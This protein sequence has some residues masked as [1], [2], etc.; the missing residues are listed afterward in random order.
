M[1]LHERLRAWRL[2]EGLTQRQAAKLA[3]ITQCR[4]SE[5]ESG[6]SVPTL[7]QAF[8]IQRA[9][10]GKIRADAWPKPKRRRAA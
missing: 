2:A 5:I 3:E 1:P 6:M 9:T 7:H 4:W 10:H 8:G